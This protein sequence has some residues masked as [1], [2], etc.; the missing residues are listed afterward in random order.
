RSEGLPGISMAWGLWSDLSDMTSHLTEPGRE[1]LGVR[2][3]SADD[4]LSLFDRAIAQH[5]AFVT[6]ARLDTSA[7]RTLAR[8]DVL[9][10]VLKSLVRVRQKLPGPQRAEL[11]QKLKHAAPASRK[12]IVLHVVRAEL[13]RILGHSSGDA[14]EPSRTFKDQGL[15][16]LGAVKLKNRLSAA[17]GLHLTSTLVFEQPTPQQVA[18]VIE[19]RLHVDD[20]P[21]PVEAAM[22]QLQTELTALSDEDVRRRVADRL[23][24]MIQALAPQAETADTA[25]RI[26]SASEDE[27]FD[28]L[29]REF[30]EGG[31]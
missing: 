6:L 3:M 7:L 23:R 2:P 27:I 10:A 29:E 14:V 4:A 20:A 5:E 11:L 12:E 13:A 1:S 15:D 21:S 31:E 8:A 17:T 9:P 28:M 26:R 16:S 22:E 18:A 25:E 19:S 30:G 24:E